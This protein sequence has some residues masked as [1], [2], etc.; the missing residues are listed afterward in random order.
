MS[1]SEI[2]LK[3]YKVLI[4]TED[5]KSSKYYI[6][7]Y[8]KKYG[9]NDSYVKIVKNY[10]IMVN[11]KKSINNDATMVSN[12]AKKNI[13]EYNKIF[14]VFDYD[15]NKPGSGRKEK[16]DTI[17]KQRRNYQSKNIFIINS[18]VCFEFWILLHF[19]NS[20]KDFQSS[21]ELIKYISSEKKYICYEKNNIDQ[22]IFEELYVKIKMAK[23]N[24]EKIES[25]NKDNPVHH[26]CSLIYLLLDDI[27]NDFYCNK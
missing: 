10:Q 8:L 23:M 26:P 6:E 16:Y 19:E 11:V 4:L 14:C 1:R 12:E 15:A 21:F 22:K 2:K 3:Q 5:S 13:G 24:A 9:F 20:T 27:E 17:I 7:K 18:S 25:A